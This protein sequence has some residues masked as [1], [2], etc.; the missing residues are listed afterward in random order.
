MPRFERNTTSRG[1]SAVPET[2]PRTR[3]CLRMRALR[4]DRTLIGNAPDETR[5][6]RSFQTAERAKPAQP[7]GDIASDV[8][9]PLPDLPAHVLALVADPLALVGFGRAHLAH[10]GRGLA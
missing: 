10:L 6:D 4:T 8:S 3:L 1:R 9:C 2:L 5:V 7:E